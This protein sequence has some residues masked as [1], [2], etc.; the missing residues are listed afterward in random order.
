VNQAEDAGGKWSALRAAFLAQHVAHA[1]NRAK[2]GIPVEP[3][4]PNSAAN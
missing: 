2:Y 1:H 4:K 3:Q